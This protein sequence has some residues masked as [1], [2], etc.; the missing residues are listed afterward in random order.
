MLSIIVQNQHG[1]FL[2]VNVPLEALDTADLINA[3]VFT[4]RDKGVAAFNKSNGVEDC[5][6]PELFMVDGDIY[7]TDAN[8]CTG[9]PEPTA[10][11]AE[12]INNHKFCG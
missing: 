4:S 1:S 7:M 6:I 5:F 10:S 9:E 3:N 11:V 2:D 8:S 12:A